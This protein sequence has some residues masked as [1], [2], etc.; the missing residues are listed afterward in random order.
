MNYEK[1]NQHRYKKIPLGF[2]EFATNNWC[3]PCAASYSISK[4][5]DIEIYPP[6]LNELLKMHNGYLK[7]SGEI[8][9]G[10][11]E[12]IFPALDIISHIY[13]KI[14]KIHYEPDIIGYYDIISVDGNRYEDEY[15]SHF[16]SVV[17][18]VLDEEY[19][20]INFKIFD[21]YYGDEINLLNRYNKG[22]IKDS[23]YTIIGL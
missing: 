16:V 22:N 19:N 13:N 17:N 8:K 2:N 1:Y 4:K 12:E 11:L 10:T 15:Q 7:C 9:W 18:P 5:F 20:I 14:T 23:I 21:P 6:T 3:V